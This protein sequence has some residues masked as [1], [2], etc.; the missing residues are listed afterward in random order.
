MMD[1]WKVWTRKKEEE[2]RQVRHVTYTK[3]IITII[4]RNEV[5]WFIVK[6]ATKDFVII[7]ACANIFVRLMETRGAG[8]RKLRTVG[9]KKISL[10][11]LVAKNSRYHTFSSIQRTRFTHTS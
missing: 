3:N 6:I 10:F 1:Q 4:L 8:R 2:E 5:L 11:N 7:Y 9:L